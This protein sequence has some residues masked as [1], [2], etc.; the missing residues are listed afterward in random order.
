MPDLDPLLALCVASQPPTRPDS[1]WG[2]WSLA[3]EIVL[4]LL[5]VAGLYARGLA[6]QPDG[7]VRGWQ[8]A[9]FALGWLALV[10][11]LVSPLC[12][13]A[14]TF[15]AAHMVQHALLVVVA[16][17]LLLAGAPG[18]TLAA[19]LPPRRRLSRAASAF[20]TA[21]APLAGSVLY[22]LAIWLWHLPFFYQAALDDPLVHLASYATLLGAGLLFW[23]PQ[24]AS[25]RDG[26]TGHLAAALASTVTAFHTGLLGALLTFS[27]V[28]WYPVFAGRSDTWGLDLMADQQVAGLIMWVPMGFA[29]LAA[30]AI[31][32]AVWLG[33]VDRR[34]TERARRSVVPLATLLLAVVLVL[35]GSRDERADPPPRVAGGDAPV[36]ARQAGMHG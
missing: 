6:R 2:A 35:P 4:P 36:D 15:A 28:P 34:Q 20:R 7:T 33:K 32:F 30:A 5:A 1:V 22:G 29:Y 3:P 13:M 8:A 9:C 26:S 21:A 19:A 24:V 10:T 18:R 16:P 12:R 31:L 25:A 23:H 17:P 14:A 11:A 27:S